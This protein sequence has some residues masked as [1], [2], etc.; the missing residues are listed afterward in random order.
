MVFRHQ[1]LPR[2][3]SEALF[4]YRG[5]LWSEDDLKRILDC[6]YHLEGAWKI[7][8]IYHEWGDTKRRD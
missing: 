2:K 7:I 5:I 3:R 1:G 6:Y 8:K 4:E